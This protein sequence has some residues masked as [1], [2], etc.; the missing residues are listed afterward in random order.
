MARP[1]KS[2]NP[3]A[4]KRELD[5]FW[6]WFT[7]KSH[8]LSLKYPGLRAERRHNSGGSPGEWGIIGP[9]AAIS[10]FHDLA[11][12]A[13]PRIGFKGTP[14]MALQFFLDHIYGDHIIRRTPSQRRDDDRFAIVTR[15]DGTKE[16]Y[17]GRQRVG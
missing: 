11:I 14:E 10:E 7:R 15:G 4:A 13:A 9:Y 3:R 6:R 12:K 17:R 16:A 1:A 8:S 5:L 2:T